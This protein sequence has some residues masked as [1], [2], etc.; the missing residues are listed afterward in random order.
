ML[1]AYLSK[2]LLTMEWNYI[3]EIIWD[4]FFKIL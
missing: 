2:M 4:L 1:V 3:V